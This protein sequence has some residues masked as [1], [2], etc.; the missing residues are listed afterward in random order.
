[1]QV[2]FARCDTC[3]LLDFLESEF[4]LHVGAFRQVD[5]HLC[6]CMVI[7]WRGVKECTA[8]PQRLLHDCLFDTQGGN[9]RK[10]CELFF[11]PGVG[12]VLPKLYL[13]G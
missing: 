2:R 1:M 12:M 6:V 3:L 13:A 8:H 4:N 10:I 11:S 9:F 5:M 7:P